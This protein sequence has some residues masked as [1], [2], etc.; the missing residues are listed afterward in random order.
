MKR[1][2]EEQEEKNDKEKITNTLTGKVII[3]SVIPNC[4]TELGKV[5]FFMKILIELICFSEDVTPSIVK[6]QDFRNGD[7]TVHHHSNI[8][9]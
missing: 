1:N 5:Q 2:Q 8:P 3:H 7:S 6:Q 4:L 9:K